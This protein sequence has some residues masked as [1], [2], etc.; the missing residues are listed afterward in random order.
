MPDSFEGRVP[1]DPWLWLSRPALWGGGGGIVVGLAAAA[2]VPGGA[3]PKSAAV[4]AL[5]GLGYLGGALTEANRRMR[6]DLMLI[7]RLKAE[8]RLSQDHLMAHGSFRSLGAWLDGL[9][10]LIKDPLR[11]LASEAKR[12]ASD[13]TLGDDA[14]RAAE[15]LASRSEAVRS[16]LVPVASYALPSPSRAPFNLNNLLREAIDLCRHRAEAKRIKF[17]ERYAI[18]PPV[19]G[20]AGRVHS[21]LLNVIVNAV[22][23]MPHEGGTIAVETLHDGDQVIGRVRDSGIGIR[24]EH[25][26]KVF[27]P[28]FTTKPEK[29]GAGLGLWETRRTLDLIDAEI[30]IRSKPHEGTEVSFLFGQAAPISAGRAGVAHPP[31]LKTNTADEGDRQIA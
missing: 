27:E 5:T 24:P 26:D 16:L 14:R 11:D 6:R 10:V 20:P 30:T 31:E 15:R 19:F 2:V 4:I 7:A 17:E 8:L 21:A 13:A 18:I 23:A 22:E 3:A 29:S 9:A 28:F 1:K 25:L 12:L